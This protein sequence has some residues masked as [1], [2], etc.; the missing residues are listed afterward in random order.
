MIEGTG[1][2]RR[3]PAVFAAAAAGML[4]ALFPASARAGGAAVEILAPRDG[5]EILPG[6]ALLIGKRLAPGLSGVEVEVNGRAR[7]AVSAPQGGFHAVIGLAPGKNEIRVTGGGGHASISVSAGARGSY[8][9]HPGVEKCGDCH[10]GGTGY[11]VAG[12]TD[13]LCYGCHDRK[14]GERHLHGPLGG[15]DC[16]SSCHDPHGSA[17]PGLIRAA[18]DS[19]CRG[20]HD[21]KSSEAHLKGA[22]GKACTRCHD[23]HS[24]SKPFLQR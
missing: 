20:C 1:A 7:Q 24:A 14:D 2:G 5:A 13:A 8:R 23:P 21:Q 3:V 18:A 22:R 9:Y 4:L 15:G 16:T 10:G 12:R 6:P 19:L 11:G 17:Y